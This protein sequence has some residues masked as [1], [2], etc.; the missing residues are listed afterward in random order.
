MA[1]GLEAPGTLE[2]AVRGAIEKLVEDTREKVIQDAVKA[3]E[4]EVR[5]SVA[6]VALSALD[7]Y[8][9]SRDIRGLVITV[10]NEAKRP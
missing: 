8:D 10:K 2:N 9:M 5:K 4:A 7:Y 1:I 6:R 3:F